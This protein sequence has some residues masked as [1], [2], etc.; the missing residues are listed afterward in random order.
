M[1]YRMRE[2]QLNEW[3]REEGEDKIVAKELRESNK[4]KEFELKAGS[5]GKDTPDIKKMYATKT[6]T[7]FGKK[8][9]N[10]KKV[11]Q[12]KKVQEEFEDEIEDQDLDMDSDLD[13]DMGDEDMDDINM[14]SDVPADVV[15][16]PLGQTRRR[17]AAT[18]GQ[19]RAA[20]SAAH[21][22]RPRHRHHAHRPC[23]RQRSAHRMGR[24]DVQPFGVARR[25]AAHQPH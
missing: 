1:A 8:G 6:T 22:P 19:T 15:R 14:E 11:A 9:V 13:S 3:W 10:E 4:M 21:G 18:A 12:K 2:R 23:Q 16:G 5:D 25:R 20:F 24:A 7:D 17:T